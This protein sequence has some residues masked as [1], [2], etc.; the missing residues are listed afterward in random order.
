M[1]PSLDNVADQIQQHLSAK[2]V[3]R[4]IDYRTDTIMVQESC[5][6]SF[7]PIHGELVFR[8]LII[9]PDS[10]QYRCSYSL[11]PGNQGGDLIDLFAKT[12]RIDRREAMR[13][14][15]T[16]LPISVDWDNLPEGEP[17][18]AVEPSEAEEA[19]EA[20]RPEEE[21][22]IRVDEG[23]IPTV[24][25]KPEALEAE[26]GAAAAEEEPERPADPLSQAKAL[27]DEEQWDE[28][29]EIF[30]T[31]LAENPNHLDAL[32]G[33]ATCLEHL[34]RESALADLHPRIARLALDRGRITTAQAF[35]RRHC[36]SAK[37]VK[38]IL[39][40]L[41][42]MI[43]PSRASSA[44]VN[45][46]FEALVA[47]AERA[48]SLGDFESALNL[49]R[50]AEPVAPAGLDL[51]GFIT[52]V[53]CQM[54]QS[55]Q[56]IQSLEER[57]EKSRSA[58]DLEAALECH[59][60][61]IEL[62][63]TRVDFRQAFIE[64]AIEDGLSP[65]LF[66]EVLEIIDGWI[67]DAEYGLAR[68][69]LELLAH[70]L[71]GEVEIHDRIWRIAEAQGDEQATR[72]TA[73][74]LATLC[75]E[76]GNHAEALRY[77]EGVPHD[78]STPEHIE[79]MAQ[80]QFEAGEVDRA[81]HTLLGLAKHCDAAGAWSTSEPLY[82]RMAMWQ[83]SEP[84]WRVVQGKCRQQMGDTEGALTL[85]EQ[86]GMDLLTMGRL[87]EA[88]EAWEQALAIDP[89]AVDIAQAQ[90][91]LLN[92]L[93]RSADARRLLNST[94]N[95][96]KIN[97]S[98]A[99]AAKF[100]R[101]CASQ[102]EALTIESTLLLADLWGQAERPEEALEALQT[103]MAQ[104]QSSGDI[105][106]QVRLAQRWLAV[107]PKNTAALEILAQYGPTAS[108]IT[109]R[110]RL[111]TQLGETYVSHENWEQALGIF[112]QLHESEPDETRFS[113]RLVECHEQVGDATQ[114]QRL[115]FH[116]AERFYAQRQWEKC[117]EALMP[118]LSTETPEPV[119]RHLLLQCHVQLGEAQEA[120]EL[121][122]V[123]I[124][125]LAAERDFDTALALAE[126]VAA[127]LPGEWEWQRIR[128]TLQLS[129]G[130][131]EEAR[132]AGM[133]LL[134]EAVDRGASA[135]AHELI[136][137]LLER[138]PD[139]RPLRSEVIR[140]LE[141]LG[142][143]EAA[144][145]E[146]LALASL[147]RS[148]GEDTVAEELLR[149]MLSTGPQNLEAR[150]GLL[151]LLVARGRTQ[152]GVALLWERAHACADEDLVE[153]EIA[154]LDRLLEIDPH[155]LQARRRLVDLHRSQLRNDEAVEQLAI[156]AQML[157]DDGEIDQ[158]VTAWE[159]VVDLRPEVVPYHQALITCQLSRGGGAAMQSSVEN[160][161]QALIARE[162][163]DEALQCLDRFEAFD[164][165]LPLW[166]RW[167]G[168][169]LTARGDHSGA[170]E[171][172]RRFS[173]LVDRSLSARVGRAGGAEVEPEPGETTG[174]RLVPDY[175]FE[176]FIIGEH[177]NFA[178]ATCKAV[179]ENPAE[180]YNPLFLYS[181]VGLGK[182]HLINAI[183]NHIAQRHPKLR[184][185]FTSVE[186]FISAL[187]EAIQKNQI[188]EFRAHHRRVDVLLIDD[189]QF[190][191][192]KER[193]QEEFF[194]LFNTLHQARKQIVI[195][196]DRPPREMTYLEK[197]LRSRFGAGVIV[198]VQPPD[199][200]TRMAIVRQAAGA[201]GDAALTDEVVSLVAECCTA[202]VRELKGA[203]LQLMALASTRSEP[204]A[205]EEAKQVL[206]QLVEST[207]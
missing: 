189:V 151:D 81:I 5:V 184:V 118:L 159:E 188:N 116:M 50:A 83:P 37:S 175:T 121:G 139:D 61:M 14:L 115:R 129:A 167:R 178:H 35:F 207:G 79:A 164:A 18:A 10:K 199:I 142:D 119:V 107:D 97:R 158:A 27:L 96:L 26:P 131:R 32:I 148:V 108:N 122:R 8:T 143:T 73:L 149:D 147:H 135:E 153:E 63:P 44:G 111:L 65:D 43:D 48:E 46:L 31:I 92:Q 42:A 29:N 25:A 181:D 117:R 127:L 183:G 88:C 102:G 34:A 155:H 22:E 1:A 17:E 21:R 179:A 62:D 124:D 146:R 110:R 84:R 59:R 3:L 169:V 106:A 163:F 2:E 39:P 80:C 99:E 87:E 160:L 144:M 16:H 100:L 24:E 55:D 38:D 82:D 4:I 78:T 134:R 190:L 172:F 180:A 51:T 28:A 152:D 40:L 133:A 74:K 150:D 206:D 130:R 90:H 177:N 95:Y 6:K 93:Q 173:S 195:T 200:E 132:E 162:A 71:P 104:A 53:M 205:L 140:A 168:E 54:G 19:I 64:T 36:E 30:R 109:E 198:D 68:E 57:L 174:W 49:Y 105:E 47:R 194:H 7:C 56:A 69:A 192:N 176:T 72:A 12:K 165:D 191:A 15:L 201:T 125:E 67:G 114:A 138:A 33:H 161:M 202:N 75:R 101:G 120:A 86:A 103:A 58:G 77:L 136:A 52:Q 203:V 156:L 204:V 123:L 45:A 171:S 137:T 60:A 13:E 85:F 196:S 141:R 112:T 166:H 91:G 197:R 41:K 9:D 186:E 113:R 76:A 182:T 187:I 66:R 94:V 20:E 193:A 128:L 23:K 145:R 70:Y 11:C 126:Q 157:A 154:E 170:L 98:P 89:A 185:L